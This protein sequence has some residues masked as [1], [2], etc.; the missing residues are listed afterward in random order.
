MAESTEERAPDLLG[1]RP[2]PG[3]SRSYENALRVL[4]A[5]RVVML[6]GSIGSFLGSLL[7]FYQGFLFVGDAWETVRHGGEEGHVAQIT[8]PVLE[9]VDSF[10]FGVVLVIF[11]YGI[12]VGF[13][14]RLPDRIARILPSWMKISGVSQL[15]AIL[16][17]VVI[18]VLIVI[19][20]R[21]VVE[22]VDHGGSFD[23]SLLVLPLAIVL[24]AGAIWLL[25]LSGHADADDDNGTTPSKP[26]AH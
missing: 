15:K 26:D 8:V 9:A 21:V 17:E 10:L 4:F 16:A 6:A 13:V 22:A 12:A 20:A 3:R 25:D 7:M 18:V 23:W 2:R 19:F 1:E 24:L 11:A 5:F 14:I